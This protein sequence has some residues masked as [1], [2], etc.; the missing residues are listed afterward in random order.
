MNLNLLKW[1]EKV[2]DKILLFGNFYFWTSALVKSKIKI[3]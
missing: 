1:L 3:V 2:V